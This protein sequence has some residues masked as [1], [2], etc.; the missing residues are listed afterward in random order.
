MVSH[1]AHP[2]A[3]SAKTLP[4]C[5]EKNLHIHV[6]FLLIKSH[7]FSS[8]LLTVQDISRELPIYKGCPVNG[9][10]VFEVKIDN[11]LSNFRL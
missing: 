1:L 9:L 7:A 4:Y 10:M 2:F 3:L 11:L 8:L 5:Q 6:V